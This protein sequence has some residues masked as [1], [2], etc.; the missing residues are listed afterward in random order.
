MSITYNIVKKAQDVSADTLE[1]ALAPSLSGGMTRCT[2][3]LAVGAGAEGIY[4]VTEY[5]RL[6][7]L[8]WD[9]DD[10]LTIDMLDVDDLTYTDGV[11]DAAKEVVITVEDLLAADL[12][13]ALT[14]SE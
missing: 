7:G 3:K 9:E 12:D 10:E 2:F 4:G 5:G 1:V 13:T 8:G 6:T 11:P 14:D